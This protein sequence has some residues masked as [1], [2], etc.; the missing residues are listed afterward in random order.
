MPLRIKYA[1]SFESTSTHCQC[2]SVYI[3]DLLTLKVLKLE[4]PV[5]G[6]VYGQV[7]DGAEEP[8]VTA[9]LRGSNLL[10]LGFRQ[11]IYPDSMHRK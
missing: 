9:R 4:V 11:I 8:I 6:R 10:T 2:A 3:I 1:C 7:V 5:L